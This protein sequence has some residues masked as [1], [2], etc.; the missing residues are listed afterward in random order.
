MSEKESQGTD[1]RLPGK[2]SKKPRGIRAE[3]Q[4]QIK[5][6]EMLQVRYCKPHFRRRPLKCFSRHNHAFMCDD[7]VERRA[8]QAAGL[9]IKGDVAK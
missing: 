8:R 7:C 3:K 2:R 6:D 9:N 4:I 5:V 1:Y